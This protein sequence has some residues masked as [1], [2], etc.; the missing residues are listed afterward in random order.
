[1]TKLAIQEE[2]EEDK[3]DTSTAVKCWLCDAS[4][5]REVGQDVVDSEAQ[6]RLVSLGNWGVWR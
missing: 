5:G 1:M 3:Y 4:Q 6:V 2:R